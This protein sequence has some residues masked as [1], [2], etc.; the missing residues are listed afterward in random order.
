MPED[1]GAPRLR[2]LLI[3]SRD[4]PFAEFLIFRHLPTSADLS[5]APRLRDYV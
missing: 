3:G 2:Q 4:D 1:V 5:A